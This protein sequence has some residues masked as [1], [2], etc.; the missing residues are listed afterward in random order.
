MIELEASRGDGIRSL[1]AAVLKLPS[2]AGS[3]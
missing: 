2:L 1:P 3:A